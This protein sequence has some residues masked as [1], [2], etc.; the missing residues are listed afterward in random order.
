MDKQ[1]VNTIIYIH[2]Y[3][4]TPTDMQTYINADTHIYSNIH[5]VYY[6]GLVVLFHIIIESI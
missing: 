5:I 3:I 2:I 6:S 4:H 1:K